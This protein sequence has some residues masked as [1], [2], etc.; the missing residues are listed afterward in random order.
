MTYRIK[1]R[2]KGANPVLQI[3]DASSG[4]VRL[5]WEYPRQEEA[6]SDVDPDVLAL[7]REEAVHRLFR[8]LFL[9]T[10]EQYLKE[11][12]VPNGKAP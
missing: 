12:V 5:A 3:C 6:Q 2:L 7:K 8:R 4:C 10:T 11:E 9:L 1:T